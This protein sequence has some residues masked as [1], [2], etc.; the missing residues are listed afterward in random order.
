MIKIKRAS[1]IHGK[2]EGV[3]I[4]EDKLCTSK[5]RMNQSK[6][7]QWLNEVETGVIGE[8]S[9]QDTGKWDEFKD[10]YKDEFEDKIELLDKI[11]A[12]K[13]ERVKVTWISIINEK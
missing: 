5:D 1:Q 4:L 11:M 9:V 12:K 7:D 6:L 8:W 10:R 3:K 13:K 2:K